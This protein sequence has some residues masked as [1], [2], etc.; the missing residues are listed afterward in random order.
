MKGRILFVDD[1]QAILKSLFRMLRDSDYEIILADS[2]CEALKILEQQAVD[3][4]V[5]DMMM[6]QM[7]GYELLAKVKELYP[8]TI[9][10][11]LSGYSKEREVF[12][13]LL[14]GTAKMYLMKPWNNDELIKTI[15]SLFELR[16]ILQDR[17]MIGLMESLENLPVLPKIYK[18]LSA[19]IEKEAGI[20]EIA[21]V[22]E[23]DPVLTA[24]VLHLANSAFCSIKTGSVQ[25]AASYLGLT[26]IKN[27]VLACVV[28]K[29]DGGSKQDLELRELLWRQANLTNRIMQELAK[30]LFGKRLTQDRSSVALTHDIGKLALLR[31]YGERYLEI[32]RAAE[33][34]EQ[35]IAI[36]E[37]K[38]FGISHQEL[39]G[40]LLNWWNLP[41]PFVEAAMFHEKPLDSPTTDRSMACLIHLA[42]YY[43]WQRLRPKRKKHLQEDV[44]AVLGSRRQT[45]EALIRDVPE[46]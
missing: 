39:G 1:E 45:C 37:K 41:Y 8:A 12:R 40:H 18:T 29:D 15:E 23:S 4:V 43:A 25:Q 42:D 24:R 28:F 32:F 13:A 34:D 30:E 35:G 3:I 5:S 26:A 44:F 19:L 31:Q 10:I 33:N 9:R 21:N 2:G 6:P 20:D 46:A 17:N 16:E 14:D 22:I 7:S 36:L 11:I 27:I 38:E